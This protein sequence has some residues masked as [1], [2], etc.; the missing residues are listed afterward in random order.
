MNAQPAAS[1]TPSVRSLVELGNVYSRVSSLPPGFTNK[2]GPL[3]LATSY[4]PDDAVGLESWRPPE[5]AFNEV[6][7]DGRHHLTEFP[8]PDVAIFPT[9]LLRYVTQCLE[10]YGVPYILEDRR[11]RP[12][13]GIPDTP[14][15]ALRPYQDAIVRRAIDVGYGV[16]DACP[17]S[18]KT[19][20]LLEIH[21]RLSLPTLWLAPTTNIL[22]QTA[23]QILELFGRNYCAHVVGTQ[24]AWDARHM[25]MVLC[26]PATA[27]GMP[28]EFFQTRESLVADE[29]HHYLENSV[30]TRKILEKTHHIFHRFGASGTFYRSGSN[31]LALYAVMS[32]VIAQVTAK[33]LVGLGYLVPGR[34]A[35]LP[36]HGPRPRGGTK[37]WNAG[38]GKTGI[39][40]HE[41]RNQ[42]AAWA[43]SILC[44]AGL[45][46]VVLVGTK[47]QGRVITEL[48]NNWVA[49]D[50]TSPHKG[51]E[52]VS[53]DRPKKVCRA[54]IDQFV[55]GQAIRGLVGTSMIGE[56]TDLPDAAALVY[57]PGGKAEVSHSQATFRPL[58]A[59]PGKRFGA[60][61]D[62]T[63]QHHE[64]LSEHAV[65]RMR[66]Y[67]GHEI[68]EV[69]V[70]RD[71]SDFPTWVA[72]IA[73]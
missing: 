69:Q 27:A 63:D 12:Q 20:C 54:V 4:V 48:M 40:E 16:L 55:G 23:A 2:G 64:K 56:G 3:D 47:E 8:A 39:H 32:E 72:R 57:A 70:L 33:Q 66:T 73:K 68:F 1:Q 46:T 61:V 25:P 26:T 17:R 29:F 14:S 13:G 18:G 50:P 60:I 43:A 31:D 38:L 44:N 58:T 11:V 22:E 24:Q 45:K 53:T 49:S 6:Y 65:E 67:L 30:Q 42:L 37:T 21:R 15:I 34:V 5:A 41:Y 52:F 10:N 19:R 36:I 35:I 9:G 28:P 59:A 71:P 51:V 62:F 7:W